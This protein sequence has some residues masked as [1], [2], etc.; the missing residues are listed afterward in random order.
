MKI[1]KDA[2]YAIISKDDKTN[3]VYGWFNNRVYLG[4][5]VMSAYN[6]IKNKSDYKIYLINNVLDIEN[7]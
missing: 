7:K 1:D 2:Y 5:W 3:I 4:R 6:Q